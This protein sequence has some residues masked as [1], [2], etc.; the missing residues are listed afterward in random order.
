MCNQNP[1]TDLKKSNIRKSKLTFNRN[2]ELDKA[3]MG[4]GGEV[5]WEWGGGGVVLLMD[6]GRKDGMR[7]RKRRTSI[8][9]IFLWTKNEFQLRYIG[10]QYEG[11]SSGCRRPTRSYRFS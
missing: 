9:T 1:H 4:G 8:L 2:L 3:H 6:R 5:G 11:L 10:S 7:D